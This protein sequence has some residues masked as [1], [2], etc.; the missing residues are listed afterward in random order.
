MAVLIEG[1]GI[2][3]DELWKEESSTVLGEDEFV[4][5]GT[6]ATDV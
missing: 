3:W 6:G 1:Q 2:D 4:S 5:L